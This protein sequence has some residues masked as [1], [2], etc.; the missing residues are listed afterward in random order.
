[1]TGIEQQRR[2]AKS[3]QRAIS[4][5]G[6]SA[7]NRMRTLSTAVALG[8]CLMAVAALPASA[9]PIPLPTPAPQP[10]IGSV[11]PPPS[12]VPSVRPGA[13]AQLS[14]NTPPSGS[15]FPF[16]IPGFGKPNETT[17]FDARQRALVERVNMYLMSLQTLIGDFVQVGPDGRKVEG[18]FYLQKPG[19]VR[20]EYNPPSPIE[21][22]ADGSSVVVRDRKLGT[23]DLYPLSQT[24]LRFLLADRI[25]LL[26]DSNVIA[27][28]ADD[29]FVS[30]M[31]EEKQ[32]LGGTHR[33][34]LMFNAKD[35]Q[36]KQWTVTDPQGYDTTVA[37]SNLE[38]GRKLDQTMF[39]IN[40]ERKEIIQ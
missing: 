26:R 19:R 37:L 27:I 39:V 33:V 24:P 10:K 6:L 9:E 13:P 17:A 32:T 38:A 15:I 25:D 22:V 18:K 21:L 29:M 5:S 1:M 20:F 2:V 7:E 28:S 35:T 12:S 23:Q 34:M 30:V 3:P 31:I 16:K 40:Y 11:P 8:L 4:R 36:L 14:Q